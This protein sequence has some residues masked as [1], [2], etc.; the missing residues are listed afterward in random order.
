MK[1]T[2]RTFLK[3]GLTGAALVASGALPSKWMRPAGAAAAKKSKTTLA[4]TVLPVPVPASAPKLLPTDLAK[5]AQ[6]GY[7]K[8]QMGEG[9]GYEKRLDL[10]KSGYSAAAATPVADLLRFFTIT[11]TIF[12]PIS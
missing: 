6:N 2:R 8:W 10:M 3:T 12:L 7:G 1:F 5:Y 4:R 11:D 9:L